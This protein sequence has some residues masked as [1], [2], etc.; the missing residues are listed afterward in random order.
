M[1][2]M[3]QEDM[4]YRQGRSLRQVERNEETMYL[5]YKYGFTF[6]AIAVVIKLVLELV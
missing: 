6:V 4:E 5:A 3:T 2:K 1:R